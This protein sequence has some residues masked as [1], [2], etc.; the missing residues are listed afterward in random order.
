MLLSGL[1]QYRPIVPRRPRNAQAP[2]RHRPEGATDGSAEPLG[3]RVIAGRE[4]PTLRRSSPQGGGRCRLRDQFGGA[5]RRYGQPGRD[6][7]RRS[8]NRGLQLPIRGLQHLPVGRRGGDR[9]CAAPGFGAGGTQARSR[10]P[11]DEVP[12]RAAVEPEGGRPGP[13]PR[14]QPL[15]TQ[16]RMVRGVRA[17]TLPHLPGETA[18]G[19]PGG[20]RH[21]PGPVPGPHGRPGAPAG[22]GGSRGLHGERPCGRAGKGRRRA[23]PHGAAAGERRQDRGGRTAVECSSGESH[24]DHQ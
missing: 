2:T 5:Q 20:A 9:A 11:R 16:G 4:P 8:P 15:R 3:D 22:P 21:R 24:R 13:G 7:R 23:R 1:D 14:A 10:R 12:L 6:R 17:P 19:R 18:G